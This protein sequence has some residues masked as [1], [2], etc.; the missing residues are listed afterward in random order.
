MTY[1]GD[2]RYAHTNMYGLCDG[3]R[4][5]AAAAI[6][7]GGLSGD[8]LRDGIGRVGSN[9]PSALTFSNG[10]SP[11][12]RGMPGSARDLF[13][14]TACSCYRYRGATYPL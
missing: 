6:A 13:Y 3:F 5:I 4:M 14:D 8:I 9:V 1:P 2:Q 7:G 11:S 10:F 12:D